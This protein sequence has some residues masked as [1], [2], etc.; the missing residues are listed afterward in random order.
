MS[1]Q[2]SRTFSAGRRPNAPN[3]NLLSSLGS[4]LQLMRFGIA[5]W[6]LWYAA[7]EGLAGTACAHWPTTNGTVI[8]RKIEI[9]KSLKAFQA[10][11]HEPKVTYKYK[12]D[13]KEFVSSR[14]K[15]GG[16]ASD[17]AEAT[18]EKYKLPKVTVH[19]DPKNPTEACLDES[20]NY[21]AMGCSVLVALFLFGLM[22]FDPKT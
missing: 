20:A 3:S 22:I 5:I 1:Y 19:Y 14:I 13:G 9:H 8:E 12:V 2:K 18:L 4:T 7:T 15:F 16:V 6:A 21:S 17:Q 11:K 10:D